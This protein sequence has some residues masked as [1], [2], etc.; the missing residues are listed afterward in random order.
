MKCGRTTFSIAQFVTFVVTHLE[1]STIRQTTCGASQL[2]NVF[3]I[4]VGFAGIRSCGP[5]TYR[6]TPGRQAAT[7]QASAPPSG[8]VRTGFV[9][10]GIPILRCDPVLPDEPQNVNPNSSP[11]GRG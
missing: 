2:A 10:R 11:L 8:S 9:I 1:Y 5:D 7:G 4:S 6:S 3:R